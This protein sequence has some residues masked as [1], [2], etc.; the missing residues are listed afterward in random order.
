MKQVAMKVNQANLVKSLKFSFTQK[1]TVVSELMQ[2]A[3][4]A[5]A[6]QVSFEFAPETKILRVSDNGCGIES[7]ET[8]LTVA[9]SGWDAEVVA[10]EHPFGIG[11]LSALFACHHLTVQSKSWRF[12]VNTEQVLSFKPITVEPVTDWD[13]KTHIT[14]LGVDFDAQSFKS[15]LEGLAKGFPIPVLFNGEHLDR[16]HALGSELDFVDTELGQIYLI[17]LDKPGNAEY[18]FDVYLQ[19][20]P[21]YKSQSYS[22]Y[23][24][25]VH[26]DSAR[27][28]ARLPDRDKL[29]DEAEVVKAINAALK[30]E[31]EK[32]LLILKSTLSAED[33]VQYFEMMRYWELLSLLN[34]VEILPQQAIRQFD[35]Y[36]VC[37]T[38]LFGS[39]KSFPEK[40]VSRTE[41]ESGQVEIVDID[42]DIQSEGAARFM[43]AWMRDS[44]IYTGNLHAGHWIHS[45][46]RYLNDE[47]M[48]IELLNE[49]HT[50]QFQGAWVWVNVVFCDGYR[51][52]IGSD[53]VEITHLAIYQGNENGDQVIMPKADCSAA[54]IEQ[55][56]TFRSE[57]DEYQEAIHDADMEAFSAFV[58]AN[59]ASD[60]ADA[61]KRLLPDFSGCPSLYG[62]AFV[63][64][65]D[66]KG[67]VAS[68]AAA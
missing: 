25:V 4:R 62:K 66:E 7:I 10:N 19:G 36:P 51:I 58:V 1:I 61:M 41:I 24:H 22:R 9:E 45:Q 26:L 6:T 55:V 43:F 29:I 60:P 46:L 31:I 18:A 13:G 35:S 42:D 30:Q 20:L 53:V 37:D 68:V 49:S 34:D 32:R 40:L 28:Y 38:E 52:T 17:G 5:N 3:R 65:L 33:F 21:I 56:A 64:N 67:Q 54:V 50:S 57:I 44:L 39:F 23:A 2:N 8:L 47:E 12:S 15:T 59:I 27:F 14:L 63:V 16:N 11:F 48:T